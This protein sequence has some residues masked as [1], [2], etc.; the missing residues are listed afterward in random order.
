MWIEVMIG[1]KS[2]IEV[3]IST[4]VNS[5]ISIN[6][7]QQAFV[8]VL[9][10]LRTAQQIGSEPIHTLHANLLF[11]PGRAAIGEERRRV[12]DHGLPVRPVA[13]LAPVPG[14]AARGGLSIGLHAVVGLALRFQIRL[15][16]GTALQT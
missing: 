2:E 3:S 10:S 6:F 1:G 13:Q 11:P 8:P 12:A 4:G 9:A 16:T 14:L 7:H 5:G 15:I